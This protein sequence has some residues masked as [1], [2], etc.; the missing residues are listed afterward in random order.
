MLATWSNLWHG[1]KQW[2]WMF[3][4]GGSILLTSARVSK[5]AEQPKAGAHLERQ[6]PSVDAMFGIAKCLVREDG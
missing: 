4:T 1:Q 5:G 3:A 2:Q 6:L